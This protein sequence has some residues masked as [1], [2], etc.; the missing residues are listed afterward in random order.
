MAEAAKHGDDE[1]ILALLE[2][3]RSEFFDLICPRISSQPLRVMDK[4]HEDQDEVPG[5]AFEILLTCD[6]NEFDNL[7]GTIAYLRQSVVN[8]LIS[9]FK[10]SK[11]E[12]RGGLIDFVRIDG[13]TSPQTDAVRSGYERIAAS[14]PN[15]LEI[16]AWESE[17]KQQLTPGEQDIVAARAADPKIS[18]VDLADELEITEGAVRARRMKIAKK[19][20][21]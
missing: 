10:H 21:P 9:R 15:T 17:I 4:V 1:A 13:D 7:G 16:I 2:F 6:L 3:S 20:K 19:L 18:N 12:K 11:A 5:I 14:N 8:E